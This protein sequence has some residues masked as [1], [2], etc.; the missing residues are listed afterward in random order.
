M[1]LEVEGA[2]I[3]ICIHTSQKWIDYVLQK[4]Y[5]RFPSKIIV[6]LIQDGCMYRYIKIY[7][8]TWII[9]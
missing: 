4:E 8:H 7:I 2:Y 6:Y 1:V 3:Y 9:A 5:M